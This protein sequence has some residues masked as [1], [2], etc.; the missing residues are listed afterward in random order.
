MK[1]HDKWERAR[2]REILPTS[3]FEFLHKIVVQLLLHICKE[4]E[5]DAISS[6]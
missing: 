3:S 4:K 6:L 5:I 1:E 2:E